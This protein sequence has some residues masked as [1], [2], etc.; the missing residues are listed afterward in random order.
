ML[1]KYLKQLAQRQTLTRLEAYDAIQLILQHNI[2]MPQIASFFSIIHTRGETVDEILG[3]IDYLQLTAIKFEQSS[4]VIVDTCGTGGDQQSTFNISTTAALLLASAGV[5]VAKHG[6][7]AVSSQSG[8]KDVLDA[9]GITMGTSADNVLDSLD[10][11]HFA[12]L[13]APDFNPI[14]KKLAVLRRTLS[15]PTTINLLGPL[16]NPVPIRH[17]ILGCYRKDLMP[18]YAEVLLQ[19]QM[20]HAII[21]H[22]AD[23][24]DEF[25]LNAVNHVIEIKNSSIKKYTIT[26][27]D[28]GLKK[29]PIDAIKGGDA[30]TNANI[31]KNVFKGEHCAYRDS[32]VFNAAAGFLVAGIAQTFQQGVNLAQQCIDSGQAHSLLST[33]QHRRETA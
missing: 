19:Q 8:S 4:D 3:F 6:G 17:K 1:I 33:L 10:N 16:L 11:H 15:I 9:L 7:R 24:L 29:S 18:L 13:F 12:F 20:K 27:T 25:S 28:V 31:I 32:V 26:A 30:N 2:P 14:F 22:A 21:V 23:G 5:K